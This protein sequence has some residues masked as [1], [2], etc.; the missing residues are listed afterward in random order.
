MPEH[1]SR[2]ALEHASHDLHERAL[3]RP[4]LAHQ[5]VNF[6]RIDFE[7]AIA[8]RLHSAKAFFDVSE[9]EQHL[10]EFITPELLDRAKH[11]MYRL[12]RGP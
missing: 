5:Q 11:G 1:F 2:I 9:G 8:E 12:R 6:A 7:V 3:P 4:V 10:R